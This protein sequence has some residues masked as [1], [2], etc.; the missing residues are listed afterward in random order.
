VSVWAAKEERVG[1]RVLPERKP[2]EA[3]IAR[4]L[5]DGIMTE[6]DIAELV[7]QAAVD[8]ARAIMRK[9]RQ[10]TSASKPAKQS[11][12]PPTCSACASHPAAAC[13]ATTCCQR[14]LPHSQLE[15]L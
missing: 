13:S 1:K 15:S 14:P 6:D 12:P 8:Q 3:I 11:A 10:P 2:R 9:Q 7:A 4:L 5:A